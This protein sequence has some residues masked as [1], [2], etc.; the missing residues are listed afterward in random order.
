MGIDDAL[1][2]GGGLLKIVVAARFADLTMAHFLAFVDRNGW[3]RSRVSSGK[4]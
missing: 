1:T 2:S 4:D 3:G